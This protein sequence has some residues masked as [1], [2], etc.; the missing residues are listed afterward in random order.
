MLFFKFIS[1]SLIVKFLHFTGSQHIGQIPHGWINCP[2]E[3]LEL[4]ADRFMVFKTPLD[5]RYN[6]RIITGKRFHIETIFLSMFKKK[7]IF[8]EFNFAINIFNTIFHMKIKI[9]DVLMFHTHLL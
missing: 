8:H 3:S 1:V 2:Q 6:N 5:K 7:V 4:I 9:V